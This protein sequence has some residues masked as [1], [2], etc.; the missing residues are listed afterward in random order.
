MSTE[1]PR[2]F[3]NMKAYLEASG[4]RALSLARAAEKVSSETGVLVGVIPNFLSAPIVAREVD[5]PVLVQ[6]V[7]PVEPGAH[8][9]SISPRL[10]R[11]YGISGAL[12]NH[13]ERRVRLDHIA[14]CVRMLSEEGLISVVCCTDPFEAGAVASLNPS[15]VAVE[16]PDLIGTGISVSKARPE[17]VTEA[18]RAVRRHSGSALPICGAGITTGE[19]VRRAIELG[20][21]GVLVA[22]AIVKASDPEKKIREMAS[23]VPD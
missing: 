1:V 7:D 18:V 5:I 16:P 14:S 10:L 4:D 6:H 15:A 3:V 19:D 17:V 11:H 22:S 12:L 13:S 8:T 9:G 20:S 21:Y 2:I 23:S